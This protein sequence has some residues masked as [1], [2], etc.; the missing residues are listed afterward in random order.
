M[1]LDDALPEVCRRLHFSVTLAEE[2]RE[3]ALVLDQVEGASPLADVLWCAEEVAVRVEASEDEDYP[4]HAEAFSGVAEAV[5]PVLLLLSDEGRKPIEEAWKALWTAVNPES[6]RT[7][8]DFDVP[9]AYVESGKRKRKH[10]STLYRS[11]VMEPL[12]SSMDPEALG[13][14]LLAMLKGGTMGRRVWEVLRDGMEE[15]QEVLEEVDAS[16]RSS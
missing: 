11:E 12:A 1:K 3:T 14:M 6:T 4:D 9:D 15:V 8:P 5:A 2:L 10:P 13:E 16:D 7:P